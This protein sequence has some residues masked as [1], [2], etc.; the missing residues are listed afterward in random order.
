VIGAIARKGNVV[1]KVIENTS[2]QTMM[3]FVRQT[4]DSKVA[5]VATDEAAGYQK[6]NREFPHEHV[7]HKA[8]EWVL[9]KV[10]TNNIESFWS[11][12][13]RG[14]IG[15]YHQ[16]SKDYLPLLPVLRVQYLC[17]PMIQNN[18][19]EEPPFGGFPL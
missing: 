11:L 10:H 17:P 18:G 5:L 14:V 6:L 15:T 7:D 19:S 16:V 3:K 8:E 1:C 13:K 2:R 12:L 9:G 4:V